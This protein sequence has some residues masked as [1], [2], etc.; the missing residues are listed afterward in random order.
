MR[1]LDFNLPFVPTLTAASVLRFVIGRWFWL[2][3]KPVHTYFIAP[4]L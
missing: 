2:K 3:V 4:I 1:D